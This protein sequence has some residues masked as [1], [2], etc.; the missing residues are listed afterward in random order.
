[1]GPELSLR[2]AAGRGAVCYLLL[3]LAACDCGGGSSSPDSSTDVGR[4]DVPARDTGT[5]AS[6]DARRPI[7]VGHDAEPDVPTYCPNGHRWPH[8]HRLCAEEVPYAGFRERPDG[9]YEPCNC[10]SNDRDGHYAP[11]VTECDD[12]GIRRVRFDCDWPPGQLFIRGRLNAP[13]N[14]QLG[15]IQVTSVSCSPVYETLILEGFYDEPY[16]DTFFVADPPYD[17][18]TDPDFPRD[19]LCVPSECV[20]D[21]P[22]Q[23]AHCSDDCSP[24]DAT[25]YYTDRSACP[26]PDGGVEDVGVATDAGVAPDAGDE[27]S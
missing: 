12:D 25:V 24:V 20:F 15:I 5:D 26:S 7:D 27:G 6:R 22:G 9:R 2:R 3:T 19:R 18:W 11:V 8:F 17:P 23:T 16:V 4:P 10:F 14:P 21:T 13:M 1:M